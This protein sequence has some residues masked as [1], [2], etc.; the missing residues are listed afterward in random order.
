MCGTDLDTSRWDSGPGVANRVGSWLTA[1][2]FGGMSPAVKWLL[3]GFAVFFLAGP[4]LAM[5]GFYW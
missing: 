5:L 4:V 3:I 1:F 2:T